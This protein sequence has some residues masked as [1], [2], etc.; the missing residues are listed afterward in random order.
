M[1]PVYIIS[2]FLGSGK[3]TLIQSLL[4][5]TDVNKVAVIEN[6][7]GE[8]SFDAAVLKRQGVRLE[9][10]PSGCICCTLVGNFKES[11]RTV[12]KDGSAELIVIEPSGVAKLSDIKDLCESAEFA[13]NIGPLV[14]VTVV[15]G[16][17]AVMYAENF[18]EFFVDQLREGQVIVVNRMDDKE[19][20]KQSEAFAYVD[21]S[22]DDTTKSYS[23]GMVMMHK[24]EELHFFKKFEQDDMSDMRNVAGEIEGSMAAM[25]YCMD[26]NIKSIS[27]FYDYEGIE[28]WCNGDWKAKKE[29]TR[30]YVKFYEDASKYVDVDFIKVK[31]HSGDK[32]NDLADEL[33]KRALGLI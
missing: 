1:V 29:G 25:K 13:G 10:L 23:Y 15:D 33:A 28:K 26:N 2:G 14:T 18:G 16:S 11:L 8:V 22:Y 17:M 19:D 30:R 12:L 6:D 32:Y 21:G 5:R 4:N 7:F 9:E 3:T 24:E 20:E 31:G 27:I